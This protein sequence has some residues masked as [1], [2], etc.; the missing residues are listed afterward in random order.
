MR[1]GGGAGKNYILNFNS[2][3]NHLS[4]HSILQNVFSFNIQ[5]VQLKSGPYFNMSNLFTKI[6]NMLY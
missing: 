2:Q 6:Y 4:V 5:D 1:G 3:S